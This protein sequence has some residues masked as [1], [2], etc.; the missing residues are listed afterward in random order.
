MRRICVLVAG[1]L[2]AAACLAV[3]AE[4]NSPKPAAELPQIK[5]LPNPFAFSGGSPVRSKEDWQRRRDEIKGLFQDYEYGH[6]PPKPEKMTITRGEIVVDKEAGTATQQLELNLA[7]GDKTLV[8][9]VRLVLPQDAKGPVPVIVQGGF[10]MRGFGPSGKAT[11]KAPGSVPGKTPGKT[12]GAK[13][14]RFPNPFPKRGYAVA[15]F[16]MQDLAADNKDRARSVGVYQLFGDKIDCGALM[17]WAWGFHRVI[18]ALETVDRIDAKKVVVTGHSRYGKAALVAGAFDE[19]IALTVPSHSGCGGAAPYRFIYGK[20][21]QLQ[22]AVRAFPHWF[23]P[24]FKQ[25]V[26]NVERL[27]VDQHLLLALVAPRALLGTEGTQDIW[28]NPQGAQLTYVAAKKV[29][30]FLGAGDRISIRYR[31][32]AHVPSNEDLL[33]FA[34]HCFFNK[35]LSEEFG[36]LPYPEEKNGFTWSAPQ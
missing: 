31:P 7:H 25:F 15:E 8:M 16:D 24:D 30:E 22:D 23:R 18:D 5:G 36:K 4:G 9:H 19:R 10:F 17:A 29:Y 20:N 27:P 2:S 33:D 35:P 1:I 14:F 34:D 21:E 28:I 6:L 32:V 12:P 13:P 11:P 3:A 26:G